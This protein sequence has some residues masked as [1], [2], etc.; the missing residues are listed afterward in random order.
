[1]HQQYMSFFVSVTTKFLVVLHFMGS[2]RES[3]WVLHCHAMCLLAFSINVACSNVYRKDKAKLLQVVGSEAPLIAVAGEDLVLPCFIKAKTSA[4]DMT[5]EWYKL[6]KENSLVHLYKDHDDVNENQAQTYRGRTSVFKEELQKGNTSLK[7]SALRVSDEGEY[8][9]LVENK[10]MSNE[11]TVHVIVEVQGSQPVIT[12]ESYD[13]SGGINLVCESRGWKPEPEVLW[14]DRK[15]VTLP[16]EDTQI[17]RETEGFS[18]KRHITVYDYSDSNRFYCRLLQKHH[19]METEIIINSPFFS[20]GKWIVGILVSSCLIAAGLILISVVL[21]NKACEFQ[22]SG[23]VLC[24]T[25]RS[26]FFKKVVDVGK[27][28]DRGILTRIKN[29]QRQ[30]EKDGNFT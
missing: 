29:Q 20:S 8:K 15:G 1:M 2:S 9:C 24:V 25:G 23:N 4:V 12:L 26:S 18:V 3:Y 14:L 28:C 10:S 27:T 17:H 30:R 6:D 11:I 7:L 21:C 5:V 13:N 16:A 22:F 19:M